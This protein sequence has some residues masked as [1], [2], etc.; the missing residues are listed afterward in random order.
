MRSSIPIKFSL[1]AVP[2]GR[3]K[4]RPGGRLNANILGYIKTIW[5]AN[6]HYVRDEIPIVKLIPYKDFGI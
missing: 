5:D 2:V 1:N 4:S 3:R 6:P